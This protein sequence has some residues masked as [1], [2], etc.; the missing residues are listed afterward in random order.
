MAFEFRSHK[1]LMLS[2]KAAVTSRL[3]WGRST[4]QLTHV[5]RDL[6]VG[7]RPQFLATWASPQDHAQPGSSLSSR[8]GLRETEMEVSLI[9][10][11]TSL[12]PCS[13]C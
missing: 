7:R 11:V 1:G 5:T 4:S 10:E 8:Q 12:L 2:H 3:E 13:V 9:S 6:A